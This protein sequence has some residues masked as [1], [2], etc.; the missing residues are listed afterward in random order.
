MH[1]RNIKNDTNHEETSCGMD[2]N[3]S[4]LHRIVVETTMHLGTG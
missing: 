4:E 2:R 1:M 3:V